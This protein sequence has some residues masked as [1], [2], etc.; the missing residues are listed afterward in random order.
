MFEV[1][2]VAVRTSEVPKMSSIGGG[3]VIKTSAR[4][5]PEMVG[6]RLLPVQTS[7]PDLAVDG[8]ARVLLRVGV[9]PAAAVDLFDCFAGR[10]PAVPLS[11]AARGP[12]PPEQRQD[13]PRHL[14]SQ[15]SPRA[16]GSLAVAA[17]G[18]GKLLGSLPRRAA[19]WERCTCVY[20]T[21]NSSILGSNHDPYD[22]KGA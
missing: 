21:S 12:L 15:E 20:R 11:N 3:V 9:V 14:V 16:R 4:L 22:R 13:C 19:R 17:V 10:H 7:H 8:F 5:T 1:V 6:R 2:V 18:F